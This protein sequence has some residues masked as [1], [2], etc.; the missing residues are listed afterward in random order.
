MRFDP[1]TD[2]GIEPAHP[3]LESS[4]GRLFGTAADLTPFLSA[5][6]TDPIL[7]PLVAKR[8][9]LRI[10]AVPTPFEAA[11][12]AIIGQL[13]SV[14]AARTVLGRLARRF[15]QPAG[16]WCSF[17][18]AESLATAGPES[19][20]SLG[21]TTTKA[22]AIGSLALADGGGELDWN[23]LLANPERADQVL[24]ALPGVGRWTSGYIRMRGLADP[25]AFLPTDL[26]IVRA[27]EARG[28]RRNRI[29][30]TAE[31]WRPWRAYAT[32]HLWASLS[33]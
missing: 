18:D 33:D 7:G 28:V 30:A 24:T 15:G 1:A 8:P 17:P 19:L 4:V 23:G 14:A 20:R 10:P 13:I 6:R 11:V 12:R 27:L 3:D 26:G 22:R 29:E 9:G 25:D 32:I 5:A 31:R 16:D 21:L 2:W